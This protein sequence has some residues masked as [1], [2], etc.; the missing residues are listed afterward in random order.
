MRFNSK[1]T[2][3]DDMMKKTKTNVYQIT[4]NAVEEIKNSTTDLFRTKRTSNE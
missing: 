3:E 1:L 4:E 2:I